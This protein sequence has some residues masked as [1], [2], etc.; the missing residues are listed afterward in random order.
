[1]ATQP[2]E[3]TADRTPQQERVEEVV[4]G[5]IEAIREVLKEKDVTFEEYRAA[6]GFLTG[7][8]NEPPYEVPLMCDLFFNATVC[9]I[10]SEK[11][12]GTPTAVEGPYFLDDVPQ[13]TDHLKA[14]TDGI[15]LDIRGTVEAVDGSPI[16][17]ARLY[18]WHSDPKGYYSGFDGEKSTEFYR[19]Y[20]ELDSD[21]KFAVST[22][23]PT[24]YTIP[25]GG[26]SHRLLSAMGRHP[27]RP[28]HV[29]FK[30]TH[31]DF[32]TVTTQAHFEGED[33]VD[34]DTVEAVR[35]SNIHKLQDQGDG[36]LLEIDFKLDRA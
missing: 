35:P 33:Y 6:A 3:T 36:K 27:W 5:L 23:L 26:I 20:I 2:L 4:S 12:Q 25:L 31:P 16:K 9:D 29:H 13:V 28:A 30:V 19:G 34:D 18:I 17:G 10:E 15:P 22:T 7:F 14:A 11:R 21:G 24:P 8:V 32:L 1:M